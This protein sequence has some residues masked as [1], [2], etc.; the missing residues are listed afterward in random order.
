MRDGWRLEPLQ[1]SLAPRHNLAVKRAAGSGQQA[2]TR[3]GAASA[4]PCPPQLAAFGSRRRD[5]GLG[6]E[7]GAGCAERSRPRR[8]R[9]IR[10]AFHCLPP[11]PFHCLPTAFSLP[12]HCLPTAFR[13][14]S[15]FSLPFAA[16]SLLFDRCRWRTTQ[17]SSG[18]GA[19][20]PGTRRSSIGG[21]LPAAATRPSW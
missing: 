6:V 5:G 8:L 7:L 1:L 18:W 21:L 2:W 16:F 4:C 11:L 12:S 10:G 15:A 9:P 19:K 17:R 13:C 20:R 3:L 14:I